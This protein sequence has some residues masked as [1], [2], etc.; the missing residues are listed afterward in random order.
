MSR[1]NCHDCNAEIGQNHMD[2]CDVER[3]PLCGGQMLSCGCRESFESERIPW[4][5]KWPGEEECEEYGFYSYFDPKDPKADKK[6]YGH[7]P[8][9][10]DDPRASH[11]LNR[12]YKECVW[13]KEEKKMVLPDSAK[14]PAI[15]V[16]QGGK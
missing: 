10:K 1:K 7:I 14:V 5:G 16:K 2:G 8:C 15:G 9:D 6:N 11:D 13:S 12:L 3:C 4:N